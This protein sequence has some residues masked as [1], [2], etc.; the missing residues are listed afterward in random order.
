MIA[1]IE[2][3]NEAEKAMTQRRGRLQSELS[4]ADDLDGL[5]VVGDLID[6]FPLM[7]RTKN[8]LVHYYEWARRS[9]ISLRELMETTISD[10]DYRPGCLITPLL[11]FRNV[12]EKGFWNMVVA[13]T[14]T[15]LGERCNREWASKLERLRLSTRIR[16][17]TKYSWS[18]PCRPMLYTLKL[19]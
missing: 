13:L 5:W 11:G 6:T 16:G 2:E 10:M 9:E 4:Q 17:A 7:A 8:A 14:E 3:A 19:I 15:D 18:K 12:G 1:S